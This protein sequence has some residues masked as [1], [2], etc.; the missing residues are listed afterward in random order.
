M[1]LG[2]I[3][4]GLIDRSRDPAP[5]SGRVDVEIPVD[6]RT[7]D[8]SCAGVTTN[9]SSAGAFVATRRLLPVGARITLR[10]AP[11]SHA[12]LVVDAEVRWLRSGMWGD[13]DRRPAGM[14]VRFVDPTP[15]VSVS[16][17]DV[18]H[19]AAERFPWLARGCL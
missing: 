1:S 8:A 10:L 19:A 2:S 14:G 11:P 18:L 4:D 5:R 17:A 16:L 6:V 12:P 3:T 9:I 13:D 7:G 15:L